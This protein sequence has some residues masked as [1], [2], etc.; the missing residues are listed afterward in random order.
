M[1]GLLISNTVGVPRVFQARVAT[2]EFWLKAGIV[3]LGSRFL[4]GDILHLGGIS[5][6]LVAVA[7][8]LSLSFMHL[9][10]RAFGLKPRLTSLLAVGSSIW[11]VS[12][13]IAAK[14]AIDADDE[15]AS[16]AIAAILAPGGALSPF[17]TSH[18]PSAQSQSVLRACRESCRPQADRAT[19][20]CPADRQSP[21]FCHRAHR[22]RISRSVQNAL[23]ISP[24]PRRDPAHTSAVNC[25]TTRCMQLSGAPHFVLVELVSVTLG[26]SS[27]NQQRTHS[28]SGLQSQHH[29]TSRLGGE[30]RANGNTPRGATTVQTAP[31]SRSKPCLC[32][33]QRIVY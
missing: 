1:I 14:P 33:S 8:T 20:A 21:L 32:R 27:G 28:A 4:L 11:G 2:Y 6:A 9:L 26:C 16:Y 15:D 7:L 22:R 23:G 17:T 19:P 24:Q 29:L 18:I 13:I 12:A 3:L 5:L 25:W 10:G 31:P 30:P